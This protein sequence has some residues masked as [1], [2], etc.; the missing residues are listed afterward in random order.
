[1]IL[2]S[3][4]FSAIFRFIW[5]SNNKLMR[6]RVGERLSLNGNDCSFRVQQSY[7]QAEFQT[8]NQ[9]CRREKKNQIASIY[10]VWWESP[11]QKKSQQINQLTQ[12]GSITLL[13]LS[14]CVC[15]S[16]CLC[17]C[18]SLCTCVPPVHQIRTIMRKG[19]NK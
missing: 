9:N 6:E 3:V 1:M 2:N 15:L 5:N 19:K 10:S 18:S 13:S 17:A 8:F 4:H 12:N 11:E 7:F 14:M 16:E